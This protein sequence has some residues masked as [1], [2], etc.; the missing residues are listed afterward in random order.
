[1]LYRGDVDHDQGGRCMSEHFV[2]PWILVSDFL[3]VI[4]RG[5]S[6]IGVYSP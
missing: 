6:S 2:V 4:C 5:G 3:Y 1:M